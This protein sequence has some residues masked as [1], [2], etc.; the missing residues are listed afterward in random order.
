MRDHPVNST[1]TSTPVDPISAPSKIHWR[2]LISASVFPPTEY[3]ATLPFL[4]RAVYPWWSCRVPPPGPVCVHV[5][6]TFTVYILPQAETIVHPLC[7][8]FNTVTLISLFTK[9]CFNVFKFW[10]C[11]RCIFNG[12]FIPSIAA[13]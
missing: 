13:L 2:D 12:F 6:S 5:A 10:F 1:S 8:I 3:V 9:L 11:L 7:Y 4:F